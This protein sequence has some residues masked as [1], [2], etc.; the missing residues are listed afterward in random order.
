V[1][2]RIRKFAF[3][4]AGA[5]LLGAGV[6][7]GLVLAL[8]GGRRTPPGSPA[9]AHPSYRVT[10]SERLSS[11][12]PGV[13]P[14]LSLYAAFDNGGGL[15][16]LGSA[17]PPQTGEVV[18]RIDRRQLEQEGPSG[19]FN[20]LAAPTGTQVGFF[21]VMPSG[22]DRVQIPLRKAGFSRDRRTGDRVILL[23]QDLPAAFRGRAA[24]PE[25]DS[26][27]RVTPDELV[28]K[29]WLQGLARAAARAGID[30]SYGWVGVH[31]FGAYLDL[32]LRHRAQFV[33]NPT[34]PTTF[35]GSVSARRCADPRCRRLGPAAH[36]SAQI[37]L[38]ATLTVQAP[39]SATFGKPAVFR[40]R[41]RAGDFVTVAYAVMPGNGPACTPTTFERPQGCSPRFR[42]VLLKIT[43]RRARVGVEG[44][45]SLV[46]PLRSTMPQ[47]GPYLL[48]PE[49]NTSGRYVAVAYTGRRIWGPMIGGS[50]TVVAP[51]PADTAV[52]LA[53][54]TIGI[55]RVAGKS[56]LEISVPGAD[57]SVK[58]V[59]R[60][61]GSPVA[62]GRMSDRGTFATSMA[63]GRRGRLVV[64]ASARGARGS[65]ASVRVGSATA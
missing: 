63:P 14:D 31:F 24:V 1:R 57:K 16:G 38:P 28:L 10:F 46:L 44:R 6:V 2:H 59:V 12:A 27:L 25:E 17:P 51:A 15:R 36:D 13:Q 11:G 42:P 52:A 18:F 21:T 26:T 35:T 49:R 41:G 50:S 45:W 58:V 5:A 19:V 55:R 40:G 64:S 7:T 39:R 23:K 48:P 9:A 3:P 65:S 62:A 47:G 37:K 53:K 34:E 33:R 32:R 20:L 30:F 61:R 8:D 22:D 54:P 29:L 56:L 4:V 60:F 43:E